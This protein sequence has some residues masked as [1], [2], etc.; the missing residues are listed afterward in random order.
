LLISGAPRIGLDGTA[1]HV[2]DDEAH[3][4]AGKLQQ[5]MSRR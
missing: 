3:H 1:G 5:L 4:A 2:T